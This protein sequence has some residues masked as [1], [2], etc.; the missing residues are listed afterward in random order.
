MPKLRTLA[1]ALTI[2]ISTAT[3]AGC[4]DDKPSASEWRGKVI[5]VCT[6]LESD[7]QAAAAS[8]PSDKAPTP[9]ELMAFYDGFAPTFAKHV[10]E[11]KAFDRPKG[12]DTEINEF[13]T[14]LDGAAKYLRSSA[15]D[16]VAVKAEIASGGEDPKEFKRLEAASTA[17]GL[18]KCNG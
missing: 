13:V 10:G 1:L 2:T 12:L 14:A 18:E 15:S 3:L 9:D 8:L 11:I 17:A 4:G 5:D 16:P 6:R 7:R